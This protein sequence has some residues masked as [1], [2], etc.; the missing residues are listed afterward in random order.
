MLLKLH[1]LNLKLLLLFYNTNNYHLHLE[2]FASKCPSQL[3]QF[4]FQLLTNWN[5]KRSELRA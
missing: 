1:V 2:A 5:L 3:Y 4:N